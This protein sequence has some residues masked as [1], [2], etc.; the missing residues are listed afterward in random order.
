[1]NT[2]SLP[3]RLERRQK[4]QPRPNWQM[5]LPE[6]RI[7]PHRWLARSKRHNRFSSGSVVAVHSNISA[8]ALALGADDGIAVADKQFG[9]KG[10]FRA[11]VITDRS[12]FKPG[13]FK[14]QM[15]LI[16][17]TPT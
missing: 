7:F 13:N 6:I 15:I 17:D 11:S 14:L 1:M 8:L 4:V 12:K 10:V 2:L 16:V 3:I 9:R 5:S